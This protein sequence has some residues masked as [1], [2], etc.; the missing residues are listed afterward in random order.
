MMI[1]KNHKGTSAKIG[2]RKACED[3]LNTL[4]LNRDLSYRAQQGETAWN[5]QMGSAT[6]LLPQQEEGRLFPIFPVV[7]LVYRN[8]TA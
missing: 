5:S 6:T 7:N 4:P 8:V 2:I 3:T 1:W